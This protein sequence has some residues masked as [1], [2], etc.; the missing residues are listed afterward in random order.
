MS[1]DVSIL[2]FCVFQLFRSL[3]SCQTIAEASTNDIMWMSVLRETTR[4]KNSNE[5]KNQFLFFEVFE[6]GIE[7]F[8]SRLIRND[9]NLGLR[10]I[11]MK[12]TYYRFYRNLPS[13][14]TTTCCIHHHW[15]LCRK[16]STTS[17][18]VFFESNPILI[19]PV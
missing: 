14:P 6:W 3:E 10:R 9:N 7:D 4:R 2:V 5:F 1:L 13:R 19:A 8:R 17:K 11:C 18:P 12:R 16:L 15:I